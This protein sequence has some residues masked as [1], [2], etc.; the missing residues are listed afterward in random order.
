MTDEE[1]RKYFLSLPE[2]WQDFPFGPDVCVFKV[3][4]KMFGT[5]GWEDGLARINLKCEPA[6]AEM[7]REIFP[8]VL[9]GY[10]MNKIHW[11]TVLLDDSVPRGEIERM[12][13][14]SFG[15][16]VKKM[17]KAERLVLEV[18]YG[19]ETLYRGLAMM[20]GKAT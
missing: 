13:D 18:T 16:V 11:N 5:L 9:P 8:S 1:V 3:R 19:K 15:L 7:L 10:H 17:A 4:T 2:A 14:H 6:Q 20:S 12:I